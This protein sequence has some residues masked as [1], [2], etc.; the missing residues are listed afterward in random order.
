MV[1]QKSFTVYNHV[2]LHC[3]PGVKFFC[4]FVSVYIFLTVVL[5]ACSGGG[6]FSNGNIILF[7]SVQ[8]SHGINNLSLYK[9]SGIFTCENEGYY[10]I[11]F[12][13]T[14]KDVEAYMSIYLNGNYIARASKHGTN[15]Y[16]TNTAIV[17]RH[18]NVGDKIDIRVGPAGSSVYV[19]SCNDSFFNIMQ[20]I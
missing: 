13:I 20:I 14:T 11:S 19:W 12:F 3:F 5:S 1:K 4:L 2:M 16:Q 10:H 18:L 17:F 15:G 9:S 7:S 8:T 6:R